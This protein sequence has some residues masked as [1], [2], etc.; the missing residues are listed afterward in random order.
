MIEIG[1]SRRFPLDFLLPTG[2][3]VLWDDLKFDVIMP[4]VN[5]LL[6]LL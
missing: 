1:R 3:F 6:R 5:E 2:A 4:A